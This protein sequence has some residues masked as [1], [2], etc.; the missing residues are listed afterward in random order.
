VKNIIPPPKYREIPKGGGRKDQYHSLSPPSPWTKGD[1][2]KRGVMGEH[3]SFLV[4]LPLVALMIFMT[5]H[6]FSFVQTSLYP[7]GAEEDLR[8]D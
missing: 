6:Y 5:V 7:A 1:H 3:R 2:R 4:L 8:E